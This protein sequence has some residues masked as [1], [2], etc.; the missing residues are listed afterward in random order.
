M[1]SAT[2][3]EEKIQ[4]ATW[5]GGT[6]VFFQLL[7]QASANKIFLREDIVQDCG[8]CILHKSHQLTFKKFKHLWVDFIHHPNRTNTKFLTPCFISLCAHY[9]QLKDAPADLL[10]HLNTTTFLS[11]LG[12]LN[13]YAL[14]RNVFV[15]D[16]L[17][18][19]KKDISYSLKKE[20]K[21]HLIA[22]FGMDHL[23]DVTLEGTQCSRL[24]KH[25]LHQCLQSLTPY[26]TLQHL[27]RL[28][29][30][31]CIA[32]FDDL[33]KWAQ[34]IRPSKERDFIASQM[35]QKTTSH[36]RKM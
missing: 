28:E 31:A 15:F 10:T 33:H 19:N 23:I 26:I 12:T 11:S 27:K 32:G 24:S 21:N 30:E 14:V 35:P 9:E 20:L 17:Q 25:E 16:N 7:E 1:I 13:L 2:S 22:Q 29:D 4:E 8:A 36:T 5:R 34:N 3:I 6:A 18:R